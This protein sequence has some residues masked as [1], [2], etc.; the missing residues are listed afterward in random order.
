MGKGQIEKISTESENFSQ[1]GRVKS[2]IEGKC[3]I[4][5][6]GWTSLT[7]NA[8]ETVT[9]FKIYLDIET[10]DS[11]LFLFGAFVSLPGNRSKLCS[12]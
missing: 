3:I 1:I 10:C 12:P 6:G 11:L 9:K 8:Y 5:S 2:E 7:M 4:A